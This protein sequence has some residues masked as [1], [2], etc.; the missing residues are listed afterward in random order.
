MASSIQYT[1]IDIK[2]I[3]ENITDMELFRLRKGSYSSQ[4]L[5]NVY[6]YVGQPLMDNPITNKVS[7]AL[8]HTSLGRAGISAM[9]NISHSIKATL[10]YAAGQQL[11]SLLMFSMSIAGVTTQGIII[12]TSV[13]LAFLTLINILNSIID[14]Y[15]YDQMDGDSNI[16]KDTPED[17]MYRQVRKCPTYDNKL[18]VYNNP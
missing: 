17:I 6:E 11:H 3:N 1:A 9:S 12:T 14:K 5:K 8:F 16:I 15:I 2:E 4:I 18:H 13:L 7:N 10:E